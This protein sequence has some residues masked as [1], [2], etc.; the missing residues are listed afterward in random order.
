MKKNMKRDVSLIRNYIA[1]EF[2]FVIVHAIQLPALGLLLSFCVAFCDDKL[3]YRSSEFPYGA[4]SNG[5]GGVSS[6]QMMFLLLLS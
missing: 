4:E 6:L 2:I 1:A 5:G 3:W